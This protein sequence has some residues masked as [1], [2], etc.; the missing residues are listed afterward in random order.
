MNKMKLIENKEVDNLY[1]N[2]KLLVEESRNRIYKTIN[3]KMINL[4][5][6]IGK[7]IEFLK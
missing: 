5:W 3:A 4:Y 1:N 6:N 7:M 2:I